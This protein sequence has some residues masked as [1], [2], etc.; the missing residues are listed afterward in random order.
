MRLNTIVIFKTLLPTT[1]TL[2]AEYLTYFSTKVQ[3]A[4]RVT[5]KKKYFAELNM[6]VSRIVLSKNI[7]CVILLFFLVQL[8]LA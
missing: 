8:G 2:V 7:S 5:L 1:V 4:F 3:I 6:I